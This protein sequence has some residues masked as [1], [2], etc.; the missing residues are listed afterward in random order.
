[1]GKLIVVYL[2]L[3]ALSYCAIS[4]GGAS[5]PEALSPTH[6]EVTVGSSSGRFA[7]ASS[8]V[9]HEERGDSRSPSPCGLDCSG[10]WGSP[11]VREDHYTFSN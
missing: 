5:A 9:Y 10:D 8:P 3:M 1:M 2:L 6:S 7:G 4:V 11:P